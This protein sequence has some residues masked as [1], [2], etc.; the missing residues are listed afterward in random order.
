MK[1]KYVIAICCGAA[2]FASGCRSTDTRNTFSIAEAL[3][4]PEAAQ[5]IDPSIE[6]R[7]ARGGGKIIKSGL[8]SNKKTN[9]VNK[10]DV[11]ACNWAFLS[12]VKQFQER[13]KAM[14]AT[15]VV[16]LISY[17]K[18]MPYSSAT[19]YECHS[20]NLMSGVALKGDLAR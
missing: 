20:G 16:N 13:A 10:S 14:G 6:L 8:V 15:K 17:Y 11:E 7:F 3:N 9:G 18:K 12:A 2:L 19:Q 1:K 5:V 4:S